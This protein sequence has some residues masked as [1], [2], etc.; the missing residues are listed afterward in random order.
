MRAQPV[1]KRRFKFAEFPQFN[2]ELVATVHFGGD[3]DLT[4]SNSGPG[5]PF[6]VNSFASPLSL[7]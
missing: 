5:D 7:I 3:S 2:E 4:E 6:V 1:V